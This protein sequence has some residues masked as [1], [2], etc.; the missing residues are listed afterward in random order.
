MIILHCYQQLQFAGLGM[1]QTLQLAR[2]SFQQVL[3]ST[4]QIHAPAGL[5]AQL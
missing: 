1:S 4:Q 5:S 2:D 3:Q